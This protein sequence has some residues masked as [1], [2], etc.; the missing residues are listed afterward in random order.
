M[1]QE[2]LSGISG[3]NHS[4]YWRL[5]THGHFNHFGLG[6]ICVKIFL[7]SSFDFRI[8]LFKVMVKI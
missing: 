6:L 3:M 5:V 1:A 7:D 8:V 2:L 4:V